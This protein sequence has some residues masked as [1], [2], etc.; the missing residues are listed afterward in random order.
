MIFSKKIPPADKHL[1]QHRWKNLNKQE[2][3]HKRLFEAH[4]LYQYAIQKLNSNFKFKNQTELTQATNLIKKFE[5]D[6]DFTLTAEIGNKAIKEFEKA[7]IQLK[8]LGKSQTKS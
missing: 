1:I 5:E 8:V 3:I 6:S 4:H 7:L 2:N